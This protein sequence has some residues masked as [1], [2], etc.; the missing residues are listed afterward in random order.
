MM[1]SLCLWIKK[2]P[3]SLALLYFIPYLLYFELLEHF[4]VPRFIIHSP[5]DDL[6]PF[7]E[8][9]I[10]PYFAWFPLLAGALGYFLFHSRDEFLNLCFLMFTGMTICLLIYTILPNGLQL[11]PVVTHKNVLADIARMLYAID[12]PTNVCPSIHVSSTVAIML[13]AARY[14]RFQHPF[15]SKLLIFFLGTAICI[16]TMVLKQHSIID[17]VLGILLSLILYKVTYGMNWQKLLAR[18]PLKILFA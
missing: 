4:A 9:F 12:T 6:I 10:L 18:T 8:A 15:F 13:V 11:R 17:V 3:Y 14:D 1:S 2:H 5:I 16:S 7:H